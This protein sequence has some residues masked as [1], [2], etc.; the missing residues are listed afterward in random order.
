MDLFAT[1]LT[2]GGVPLPEDRVIDGVNLLPLLL[3]KSGAAAGER[4]LFYYR[5]VD[6]FAVRKGPWKAHFTTQNGYGDK[7]QAHEPP[8]LYHL[9]HDPSEKYDVGNEYPEILADIKREVER[10]RA[11]LKP[12][13]TQL[14]TKIEKAEE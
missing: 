3:G 2:C 11:Q 4:T 9:E 12:V 1:A 8:R 6:I 10:H 7:P 13:K 5:G 14:E